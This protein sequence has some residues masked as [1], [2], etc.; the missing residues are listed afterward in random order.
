[1]NHRPKCETLRKKYRSEL[2]QPWVTH[3]CMCVCVCVCV[4]P[5]YTQ[6]KRN[7]DKLDFIKIKNFHASMDSINKLKTQLTE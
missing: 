1:M 4:I 7:V 3:L 2:S 6:E 5:K